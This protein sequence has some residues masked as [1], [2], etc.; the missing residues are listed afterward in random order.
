MDTILGGD[1]ADSIFGGRGKG[2]LYFSSS[3]P[4]YIH[5]HKR[6]GKPVKSRSDLCSSRSDFKHADSIRGQRGNDIIFGGAK[7]V[8]RPFIKRACCYSRFQ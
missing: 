5:I 8:R 4:L 6:A 3:L 2:R 1:G 7:G